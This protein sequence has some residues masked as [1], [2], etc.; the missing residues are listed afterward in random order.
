MPTP[1]LMRKASATSA[2]RMRVSVKD[3]ARAAKN[4]ATSAGTREIIGV[5]LL[6][7]ERAGRVAETLEDMREQDGRERDGKRDR[8]D[9]HELAG[10]RVGRCSA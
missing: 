7:A 1:A 9:Q 5:A 2:S 3:S 6:Q 10:E 4:A 8:A